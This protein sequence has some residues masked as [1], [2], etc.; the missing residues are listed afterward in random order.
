MS[1][2][3]RNIY[4]LSEL[5]AK[6]ENSLPKF[7]KRRNGKG[8]DRDLCIFAGT[9][10]RV[11]KAFPPQKLKN[12]YEIK[13]EAPRGASLILEKGSQSDKGRCIGEGIPV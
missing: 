11:G 8:E 3:D 9:A 6:L 4:Q 12:F 2:S 5:L 13:K 1:F 7:N 10:W